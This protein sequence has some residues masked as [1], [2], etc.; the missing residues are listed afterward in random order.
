V[1]G[2]WRVPP[3][4]RMDGVG[5]VGTLRSAPGA[6]PSPLSSEP[7]PPRRAHLRPL[8]QETVVAATFPALGLLIL[9][10][11][12]EHPIGWLFCAAGLLGGLD[13]FC[14]EYAIYALLAQPHSLPGGLAAAWLSGWLWAPLNAVLVYVALLFP[15][16]RLP[17]RRWR[18][19]AWLNGSVAVV[20]GAIGGATGA[21]VP[22]PVG[23]VGPIENPLG[24][25]GLESI[26]DLVKELIA[27]FSYGVLGIMAAISLFV[28]FHRADGVERQQIKWL[29]YAASLVVLGAIL[30]YGVY[31]ATGVRWTW[32]VGVVLLV[33]GFVATP[34]AVSVAILKYRLYDIDIIINRT[35]V[36]G[37]LTVVLAGIFQAIDGALHYLLVT[38][39]HLHSLPGAIIAALVVG[40]LFH[41]VRHRIQHFVDAHLPFEES[42]RP[43]H[44]EE[45]DSS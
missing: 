44:S 33:S 19:L 14:S 18:P 6:K 15:N 28:R 41:P 43:G 1:S 27:A 16:G 22:G 45:A 10:R 39:S 42:G 29:A 24:I 9:S 31:G 8:A 11:R 40:A 13:H 4:Y 12:P 21:L 36:Y 7:L 26:S 25:E 38:L 17:S 30:A 20:G 5:G 32:Q 34:I 3:H 37:A 23:G 2:G 35:L